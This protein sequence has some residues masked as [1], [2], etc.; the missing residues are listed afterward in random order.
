MALV[1]SSNISDS[2]L[3][4]G[5][6]WNLRVDRERDPFAYARIRD[7]FELLFNR[8][9]PLTPQWVDAYE[10]LARETRWTLPPGE[11]EPEPSV[12]VP[13]PHETQQEALDALA[14]ARR[15]GRTRALVVMATGLGKTLLAALDAEALKEELGGERPAVSATAATPAGF[16]VLCAAGSTKRL[17][18]HP[19]CASLLERRAIAFTEA[20]PDG[21]TTLAAVRCGFARAG[22]DT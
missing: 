13:T 6:E 2:A 22:K 1:G 3:R 7:E 11:A 19:S 4:T 9:R 14:A 10:K 18:W 21:R 20:S 17:C 5:V 15:E 8:A 16:R 12:P